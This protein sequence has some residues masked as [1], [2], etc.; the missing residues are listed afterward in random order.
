MDITVLCSDG[1]VGSRI[2]A[3]AVGRRHHVR[4]IDIHET[5]R[6]EGLAEYHR[7]NI[8]DVN[9]I[10]EASRGSDAVVYAGAPLALGLDKV[11]ELI[12]GVIEATKQ[13]GVARLL[14]VGGAGTA[15]TTEGK[16][17]LY[18]KFFS[19]TIRPV[20]GMHERVLERMR[21]EHDL[22]WVVQ[23]PPA[24]MEENVGER[25]GHYRTG[26]DH[27]VVT[28]LESTDYPHI[29]TISMQDYA[30]AM[31]DEIETPVHHRERYTVGY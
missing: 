18:T 8:A 21:Q 30:V 14:V 7:L 23:T 2:A 27:L 1:R 16:V 4:G 3:E 20:V 9:G 6:V 22:D 25:T 17:Y 29:S 24:M 5:P 31:V 10:A 12:E 19:K 26:H 15:L 11:E 13:A 28:D